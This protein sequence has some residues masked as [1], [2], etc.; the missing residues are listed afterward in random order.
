MIR[1]KS[2]FLKRGF[3]HRRSWNRTGGMN[4][5]VR[6]DDSTDFVKTL[7]VI[8][9]FMNYIRKFCLYYPIGDDGQRAQ[10]HK[11]GLWETSCRNRADI[12][13]S[14]IWKQIL[15]ELGR[16]IFHFAKKETH[17]GNWVRGRNP[18]M[19]FG[20]CRCMWVISWPQD[21]KI[22]VVPPMLNQTMK[23]LFA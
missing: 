17:I 21:V 1:P 14:A 22:A 20:M 8:A 2:W 19:W 7:L 3:H 10:D 5:P 6:E 18:N 23:I 11:L 15:A 13:L 16:P 4:P 9:D 12:W